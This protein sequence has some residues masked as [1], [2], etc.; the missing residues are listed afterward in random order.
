MGDSTTGVAALDR[1]SGGRLLCRRQLGT[2]LTT[3]SETRSLASTRSVCPWLI[4]TFI[5][6]PHTQATQRLSSPVYS[7]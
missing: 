6:A 2:T 1:D 3:G 4:T 5:Y 7:A